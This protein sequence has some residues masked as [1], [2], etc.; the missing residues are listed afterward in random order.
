MAEY[1]RRDT[2]APGLYCYTC[3]SYACGHVTDQEAP[4]QE[5]TARRMRGRSQDAH[6]V[7]HDAISRTKDLFVGLPASTTPRE[8]V[9]RAHQL[10]DGLQRDIHAIS[11]EIA[12]WLGMPNPPLPDPKLPEGRLPILIH[13]LDGLAIRVRDLRERLAPDSEDEADR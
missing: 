12:D 1:H 11:E 5:P 3:Q 2:P 10:L 13:R 9:R 7:L 8:Y 4:P 6:D